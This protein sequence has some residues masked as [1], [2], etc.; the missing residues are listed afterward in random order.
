MEEE[1]WKPLVYHGEYFGDTHEISNLGN[2]RNTKT[3]QLLKT[4][5]N[6]SNGY[7]MFTVSRGGSRIINMTVHRAVA[8]NFVDGDKNLYINHKDGNKQ[9]NR[10]DNLEF[11]THSQNMLHAIQNGLFKSRFT[12]EDLDKIY[13]LHNDG[14]TL[15]GIAKEMGVNK[16]TIQNC[17]HGNTY[18]YYFDVH[19][20][21]L[22]NDNPPNG[23]LHYDDLKEIAQLR[24]TGMTCKDIAKLYHVSTSVI[25]NFL[26][27]K[28]Y[29]EY[30]YLIDDI[31]PYKQERL[32]EEEL[33]SAIDLRKRGMTHQQIASSLNISRS[34][35]TNFFN[36]K[37]YTQYSYLLD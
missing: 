18:K 19:N 31:E 5:L 4:P 9:N 6:P 37:R 15:D 3:K 22:I 13:N 23:K 27:G 33:I 7:C 26:S 8:E 17:L 24:R 34:V 10:S 25:S 35:I 2:L 20:N 16:S 21:N 11:V 28:H 29:K 12:D 36:K 30:Q 1:I 14:L 32:S